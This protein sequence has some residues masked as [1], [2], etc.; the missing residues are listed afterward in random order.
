M[1]APPVLDRAAVGQILGV[2]PETVSKYLIGSR[3][4]G[5][6]VDHPFPEPD[7]RIG[8]APYWSPDRKEE[9][10]AWGDGRPGQGAGGGRRRK[11]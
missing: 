9:I 3:K 7:G 4:G 10:I 5:R 11:S 2:S 8:R 6:Y 1:D